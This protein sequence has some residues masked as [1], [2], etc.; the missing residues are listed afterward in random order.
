MQ[1][2]LRRIERKT[3]TD[4]DLFVE[5]IVKK[6]KN[7]KEKILQILIWLLAVNLIAAA[8][9]LIF[10]GIP[11]GMLLFFVI[12]GIGYGAYKLSCRFEI[13]YEYSIT[14]GYFDVDKII[15][16]SKRQRVLST[17]CREFEAFG[18]YDEKEHASKNYKT[19]LTACS[20][21]AEDKWYAAL[22]AKDMGYTLVIFTP[23]EKVLGTLK[24]YVPRQVAKDAFGN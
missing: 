24:K 18:R 1:T 22:H 4:M 6:E 5:Q 17:T 14:N 19:I 2:I 11:F 20:E 9:V 21:G 7:I 13:E 10:L 8:A 15:A 23:N 12:V 3:V 16:K